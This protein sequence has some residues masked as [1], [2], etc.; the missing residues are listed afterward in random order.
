MNSRASSKEPNEMLE[1]RSLHKRYGAHEVV[2]DFSH[3]FKAGKITTILGPSGSGK[4]TVLALIAGLK[5]ADG[6]AVFLDDRDITHVPAERRDFGMV[7]QNY[8]LFPHLTVQKN[9]EFGLRVRGLGQ[10]ERSKRARETLA[11]TRIEQLADR[12]ITEI[13]GGEQQRVAMARVLAIRPALLLMDEPLSALDAKLREELRTELFSL[14]GKLALTTIY[15]TH[16]QSEAMSLG[17]EMIIV[18]EGRIEQ[19]GAP[20]DLYLRP[21]NPFVANFLGESNIMAAERAHDS[22]RVRLP[23]ASANGSVP[24]A[25]AKCWAMIRPES[26]EI[27]GEENADFSATVEASTFLGNRLRLRLRAGN[28]TLIIDTANRTSIALN[29]PVFVRVKGEEI[30]TWPR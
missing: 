28:E 29:A 21:A 6:G 26:F 20:I 15:V 27:V 14:L 5:Q 4:S 9:V 25:G 1:V 22:G 16:D 10:P 24:G 8:S 7:F 13:S 17:H 18:N 30:S 19:T 11:L 23:F 3:R 2:R 12:R